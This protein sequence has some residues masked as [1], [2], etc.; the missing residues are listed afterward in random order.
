[1]ILHRIFGGEASLK[2]P[3]W[4]IKTFVDDFVVDVRY[5]E[6]EGVVTKDTSLGPRCVCYRRRLLRQCEF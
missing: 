3:V 6:R 5:T 1:M 4:E 2:I